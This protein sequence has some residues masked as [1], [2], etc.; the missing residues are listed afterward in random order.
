M[1]PNNKK[2]RKKASKLLR[3]L[4][5]RARSRHK[6]NQKAFAKECDVSLPTIWRLERGMTLSTVAQLRIIN[7]TMKFLLREEKNKLKQVEERL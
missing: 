3:G 6:L 2:A 5:L 1:K 4:V 7:G